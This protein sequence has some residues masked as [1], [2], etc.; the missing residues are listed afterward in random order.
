MSYLS[1]S[2]LLNRLG[3]ID[4]RPN[5]LAVVFVG[6]VGIDRGLGDDI[7]GEGVGIKLSSRAFSLS[8]GVVN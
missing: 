1:Y 6:G 8:F 2:M 4:W 3:G 7:V 5:D